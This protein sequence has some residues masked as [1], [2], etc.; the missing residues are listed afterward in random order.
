MNIHKIAW[1]LLIIGGL[2]WLLEAFGFGVGRFVPDWLA[3]IIYILV[4]LSA[5]YE[6]VFHK[7]IC[8]ECGAHEQQHPQQPVM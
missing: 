6:L 1:I 5:I 7:K 2:N 4:G 8:R 3:M